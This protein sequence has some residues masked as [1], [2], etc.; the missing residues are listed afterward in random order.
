MRV[1]SHAGARA[2]PRTGLTV[3]LLVVAL[4]ALF[5]GVAYAALLHVQQAKIR[6]ELDWAVLHGRPADPS[7]CTWI[8]GGASDTGHAGAPPAGFPRHEAIHA[9]ARTGRPQ[10]SQVARNGTVYHVR[11]QMRGNKVVQVVFDA[12]FQ[13]AERRYLLWGLSL[14][15]AAVLVAATVTDLRLRRAAVL[16]LAEALDRQRRFVADASHELR[17]PITRVH[18]AAQLLARRAERSGHDADQADLDRLLD[19]TRRLGEIVDELL[20]SARLADTTSVARPPATVDLA[21]LVTEAIEADA[22]RAAEHG[23]TLA[24]A[25]ADAPVPVHG[26]GPALRRVVAE[27]LANALNHTP[28]GGRVEVRLRPAAPGHVELVVTD[29]G[30]GFDP[31]HADR[32]FDRFHRGPGSGDR[33]VGLGLA[34][35]R[36][37]VTAHGGTIS[38]AGRPGA[39][40]AFTVRL[41]VRDGT[42]PGATP[43]DGDATGSRWP[44]CWRVGRDRA[45]QERE[46]TGS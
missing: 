28:A 29:S 41:P 40:A 18:T 3:G 39:G 31:R 26:V 17:A 24:V 34:L 4:L 11:T 27:L 32:I 13:L 9:V 10:V 36:E 12:R 46:L 37:V 20:L 19:T 15:A 23:V 5:G 45:G 33:R 1:G 35:I 6:H 8:F 22:P 43:P 7:G 44:F 14:A 30:R 42:R 2:R 38:A 16:P 21:A 25:G